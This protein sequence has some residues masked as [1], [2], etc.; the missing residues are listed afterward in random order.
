[1]NRWKPWA[2][3]FGLLMFMCLGAGCEATGKPLQAVPFQAVRPI[4]AGKGIVYIY[5][6]AQWGLGNLSTDVLIN[7]SVVGCVREKDYMAFQC[8]PGQLAAY[9]ER[10]NRHI[11]VFR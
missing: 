7:N 2:A 10:K 1:M 3:V 11:E 8:Q 4:P 5:A 9:V 6:P